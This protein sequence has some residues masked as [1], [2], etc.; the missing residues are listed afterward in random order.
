MTLLNF[1]S[2]STAVQA[3]HFPRT[4]VSR[5]KIRETECTASTWEGAELKA[6]NENSLSDSIIIGAGSTQSVFCLNLPCYVRSLPLCCLP[7]LSP[8]LSFCLP[9]FLPALVLVGVGHPWLICII[10]KIGPRD[11]ILAIEWNNWL[12]QSFVITA[13]PF[14]LHQQMSVPTKISMKRML[15]SIESSLLYQQTYHRRAATFKRSPRLT[16]GSVQPPY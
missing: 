4:T 10:A 1:S 11:R 3:A 16:Q 12:L 8:F 2:L 7:S 5:V 13:S 15:L 9:L 6:G 14:H